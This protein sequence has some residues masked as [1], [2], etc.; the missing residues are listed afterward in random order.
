MLGAG[1]GTRR[2]PPS[3]EQAVTGHTAQVEAGAWPWQHH[4]AGG[5]LGGRGGLFSLL[6]PGEEPA[7]PRKG[8][9]QVR[10]SE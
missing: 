8:P 6:G 1:W 7:D 3:G 9:Q 10:G 5:V 2:W 4:L